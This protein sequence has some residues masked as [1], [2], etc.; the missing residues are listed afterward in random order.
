MTVVGSFVGRSGEIAAVRTRLRAAARG[1][2]QVVLVSGE[3]GIGKTRLAQEI[4]DLAGVPTYWGRA[5]QDEGSPPYWPFRQVLRALARTHEPA[6]LAADLALVAPE[7]GPSRP[8][9]S[10]RERFRVFEAVTEYLVGAVDV[11]VVLDDV[12]WA[13]PPTL[14]LLVHLAQ[15]I[16]ES[17]V[18][19]VATYRDTETYGREAM[20]TALAALAREESVTR[21]RLTGLTET[22]VAT[23][24]TGITGG[25]VPAEV[26][27]RIS[28]RTHGNPFFVAE[29][30]RFVAEDSLPEAVR[31]AVRARLSTL[32]SLAREV[33]ATAAVLGRVL[34]PDVLAAVLDRPVQDVLT[35]LDESAEAGITDG[36]GFTHDLVRDAARLDVPTATRLATHRRTARYLETRPDARTRATEVAHHWLESLPTGDQDKAA[37]WAERAADTAMAQ[38]AWESAAD[39]Y[40]RA[41]AVNGSARLLCKLGTAQLRQF[42][43]DAAN[44]SLLQAAARAR[45]V[46]DVNVIAEVALAMEGINNYE[47]ASVGKALCDEALAAMPKDDNPLRARLL[48]QR[49]AEASFARWPGQNEDAVEALAIAERTG[50][51]R[52]LRSALRAQQLTRS[53]PD[54][55]DERM[56]LGNRMLAIG[57]ADDDPEAVMWGRLWRFDAFCQL[58]RVAD[59][60]A[61][62]PSIARAAGRVRTPVA[63]WHA[64]RAELAIA[65]M[66]GN[67]A[68]AKELALSGVDLAKAAGGPVAAVSMLILASVASATGDEQ[69]IVDGPDSEFFTHPHDTVAT[70]V[71]AFHAQRG[72][73]DLARRCYQPDQLR[74]PIGAMRFTITLAGFIRMAAAFADRDTVKRAYDLLL[75]YA[76]AVVCGGA[77]VS[78]SLGIG[79]GILGVGAAALGRLDD[80][81]NHLRKAIEGDDRAGLRPFAAMA[82]ADLAEVLTRR[83]RVGDRVEAEALAKAA[84]VA[85]EQ[86]GMKRFAAPPSDPL[87]TREREVARLVAQGLTN[88]QIAA[89]AHISV[90]TVE[91]H[92]Q[93]ILGKLGLST[94]TRIATWVADRK[95]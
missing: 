95:L 6:D 88:K 61:E 68:R 31:D 46:R 60:E 65:Y 92:V 37:A 54:G 77:G 30:G 53:G 58:A 27:A 29:L 50:D 45:E 55:V 34:E 73:L 13:D 49:A 23:Q 56:A 79:H 82:R 63:R 25:P 22:E 74:H 40:G 78:I 62:L 41:L 35:A 87:S 14:Q 44:T 67:F 57:T 9:A 90:R 1:S 36:R 81:V 42:D 24:L 91:T 18:V 64:N 19:V 11:L 20:S 85:A 51:P 52:A 3:P 66:R 39:L 12:Q 83:N 8:I 94:R 76:D 80:A 84:A 10:A 48:A 28:R 72:A 4:A 17:R 32:S 93:H 89:T 2:G 86:L 75:P 5:V 33:L 21:V 38:L 71:G 15:G 16:R 70:M 7:V 43:F 47:W 69:E 26:A 59:A